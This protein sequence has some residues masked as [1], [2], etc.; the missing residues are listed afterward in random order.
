MDFII[1]D[2]AVAGSK[3]AILRNEDVRSVFS[4]FGDG[5]LEHYGMDIREKKSIYS[6]QVLRQ[7]QSFVSE[8]GVDD[9]LSVIGAMFSA[10]RLGM[11]NGKPIG[12]SI[13]SKSH[14]WLANQLLTEAYNREKSGRMTWTKL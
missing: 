1:K 13:F 9:A 14:R 8:F 12:A 2:K 11:D 5:C 6:A 10:S 4:A 3:D 7:V